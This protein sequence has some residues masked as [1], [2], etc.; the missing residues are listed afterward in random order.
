MSVQRYD[1]SP[2]PARRTQEGFIEDSPVIGRVGILEYRNHDGG[3]RREFRPPEEAFNADSLAS[4]RGKPVTVGHPGS[5]VRADNVK[6]VKPIGTVLSP[7][8]AD[9]DNIRADVVIYNLDT[10]GRELSCG[11]SLD[12]DET[13]GIWNGQ[14]YDA[15]QRNIR[16]NHVA[17][18]PTGRAGPA[19]RL[20]M[21]SNQ[22]DEEDLTT[23]AKIRLDNGL[24]YEASQEV[25][26]AFEKLRNDHSTLN[27]D[28][29]TL[30]QCL[31]ATEA[32]RDGLKAKVDGH[33][34]ELD[35]VRK[36]SEEKLQAAVS[37]RVAIL[38]TA[39]TFKIDKADEMTERQ[40][41]EAIIK[42]A[43]GDAN[44][45][46]TEKSDAY[47][48]AAFDY[49][50]DAQ[51]QDAMAKQ[52][53]KVHGG[54]LDPNRRTDSPSSSAEA[55]QRMIERQQNAYKGGKE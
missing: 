38:G 45:D 54:E 30:K 1:R 36:D 18:V 42:S 11:Y 24:E 47:I 43:R 3:I 31:D 8:R 10:A 53:Q 15:V 37:S 50:V 23:M 35:R 14:H 29:K 7:G 52:R 12:L 22:I 34:A 28:H 55:R 25:I 33:A 49:A 44:L 9:G 51:R 16:Y 19:A 40:I 26:V 20:N 46:L 32:E 13:P 17:V 48:D 41:K 27:A 5:M 21:D 2:L 39:A 4:L 6:D